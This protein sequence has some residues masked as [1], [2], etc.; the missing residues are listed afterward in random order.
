MVND[1]SNNF[2]RFYFIKPIFYLGISQDGNSFWFEVKINGMKNILKSF[3][4]SIL[5]GLQY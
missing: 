1:I 5:N 2:V 4:E 3:A